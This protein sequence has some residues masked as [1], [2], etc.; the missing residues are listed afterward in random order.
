MAEFG[1]LA[2][3]SKTCSYASSALPATSAVQA[4]IARASAS[5]GSIARAF[6]A[7]PADNSAASSTDPV[8]KAPQSS[9]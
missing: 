8:P 7:Q 9:R 5:S 2:L 4:T 3:A 1:L 6:R